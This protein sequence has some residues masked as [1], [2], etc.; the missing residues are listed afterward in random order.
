[1]G[2]AAVSVDSVHAHRGG[3]GEG[4]G[5]VG[6]AAGGGNGGSGGGDA[7]SSVKLQTSP[8]VQSTPL[9][10]DGPLKSTRQ[11]TALRGTMTLAGGVAMLASP[12]SVSTSTRVVLLAPAMTRWWVAPDASRNI[13]SASG[14]T[15]VAPSGGTGVDGFHSRRPG[16]Q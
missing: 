13:R 10:M 11:N 6:G 7:A 12:L 1:M 8:S 2:P 16:I 14:F 4:A 5:D 3:G 9:P 15:R